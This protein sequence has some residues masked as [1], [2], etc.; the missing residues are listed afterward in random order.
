MAKQPAN[1]LDK[2]QEEQ[3]AFPTPET[4]EP[5]SEATETQA[6][7][8]PTE[9][10]EPTATLA[11]GGEGS[12][13]A[14]DAAQSD[15]RWQRTLEEAGFKDFNDVNTAVERAVESM[16][17]KENQVQD[18]ARQVKFYQDQAQAYS[19]RT[20]EQATPQQPSGSAAQDDRDAFSKL[21][22]GWVDPASVDRYLVDAENGR[23][24]VDNIDEE[25]KQHVMGV[26]K[27]VRQ[28]QELLSDPRRFAEAVD[29]RVER[30]ISE[31]FEASFEE[32]QTAQQEQTTIDRFINENANWLYQRDPVT[33]DFIVDPV[34]SEFVYSEHGNQFLQHMD[35]V[36]NDGIT[37]VSKQIHWAQRA[38]GGVPAPASQPAQQAAPQQ[39]PE[40]Q[41]QAQR[42]AM[43]GRTNQAKSRQREFNGV[44][45]ERASQP[46]G[47]SQMTFGERTLAAMTAGV[48]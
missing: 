28:W 8:Q 29:S 36:R 26:D 14:A 20:Y 9:G 25:T 30:M 4:E 48:E 31:K 13:D 23:A 37:S 1:D 27:K 38:M 24:F 47:E 15:E 44:T 19:G 18:L 42:Q 41:A 10:A 3:D 17:Q 39:T 43:R 7:T 2:E 33:G 40:E 32:K 21:V 22:D 46:T 5:V 12:T 16:R 34:T 35:S 45:P 11:G 6:E